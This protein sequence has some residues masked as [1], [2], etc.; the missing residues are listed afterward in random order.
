MRSALGTAPTTDED[1]EIPVDEITV[2][3]G[4]LLHASVNTPHA[5]ISTLSHIHASRPF[6]ADLK[7]V[8]MNA[9]SVAQ[10]LLAC[11][12]EAPGVAAVVAGSIEDGAGSPSLD[13]GV[14]AAKGKIG[15]SPGLRF[16]GM[17]KLD[18]IPS[19]VR[20]VFLGRYAEGRLRRLGVG[21]CVRSSIRQ[22][23]EV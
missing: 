10:S 17:E 20:A 23:N 9:V 12:R 3:W 18:V 7:V 6:D 19:G 13:R 4:E 15:A 22:C 2:V 8:S 21:I 16:A 5:P 11:L 1:D 14:L